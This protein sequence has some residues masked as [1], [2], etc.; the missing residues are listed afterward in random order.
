MVIAVLQPTAALDSLLFFQKASAVGVTS[1]GLAWAEESPAVPAS[2]LGQQEVQTSPSSSL[3]P[4]EEKK[5]QPP[6][7]P[8][9]KEEGPPETS[10]VDRWH[11]KISSKIMTTAQWLDSFF[12]DPNYVKE[13]NRSY[14]RFRYDIFKEE[15]SPTTFKPAIDMRLSLPELERKTHLAFSAAPAQ[16][17]TGPGAPV[18]TPAE[19]F[20]QVEQANL[21]TALQYF[22]RATAKENFVVLSGLQFSKFKPVTFLEPRYR[23]LVPLGGWNFRFTQDVLWRTDTAWQIDSRFE[24]ERQLPKD[25]FFRTTIDGVWASRV[26]GY[27]YSIAFLLREPFGPTNAIDYEWINT[28]QTRPVDEL[29]EIDF[30]I[31]YRHSFWREWLFFEVSPQLRFPQS[32]NFDN[33]P[34]IL[35]R[36]EMF[37]GKTAG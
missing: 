21:T 22:L 35:F 28:Y 31:R 11:G 9:N 23:F 15:Y 20:G 13:E 36:L 26:I 3:S 19:R 34:G 17:L 12:A 27:T 25:F 8:A 7:G 33:I 29:S 4:S 2:P 16:T 14:V 10:F 1:E 24:F 5:P 18:L 6:A 37:F 30:R 32:S